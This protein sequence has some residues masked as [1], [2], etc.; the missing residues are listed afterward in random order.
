[1]R[2]SQVLV[3]A[4]ASFLFASEAIAVTTDSVQAKITTVARGGPSQRLLRSYSKPAEENDSADSE[5]WGFTTEELDDD[6][7]E[8]GLTSGQIESLTKLANKWGHS[9]D[10]LV[11]GVV[12]LSEKKQQK[13]IDRV[14]AYIKENKKAQREAYNAAWRAEH[15]Y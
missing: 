5:K 3:V 11:N 6:S 1:M 15:G 8:R 4:A 12:R 14:N 7:E 10:D 2:L 9:Y 13:W